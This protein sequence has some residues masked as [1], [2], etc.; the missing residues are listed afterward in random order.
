[1][2]DSNTILHE[3]LVNGYTFIFIRNKYFFRN[4]YILCA[5]QMKRS[6][7]LNQA[8]NGYCLFPML[9][10]MVAISIYCNMKFKQNLYSHLL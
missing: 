3:E 1:M 9:T 5:I 7:N 2:G 10:V 6:K 8:M 4:A